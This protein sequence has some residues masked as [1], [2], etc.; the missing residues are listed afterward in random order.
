MS[1]KGIF[2]GWVVVVAGFLVL[3]AYSVQY[4]FGIFIEPISVEFSWS[5]MSLSGVYSLSYAVSIPFGLMWGKLVDKIGPRKVL[6][7]AG[8]LGG[9]GLLSAGLANSLLQ[10]YLAYGFLWGA[11]WSS[12]FRVS[13]AVIRRWFVRRAGLALGVAVCGISIGT[14]L[15]A[16]LTK[17]LITVVNW[18]AA[19][20]YVGVFVFIFVGLAALIIKGTPEEISMHPD[21]EVGLGITNQNELEGWEPRRAIGSLSFWATF[22]VML[23]LVF[24]LT[25]VTAHGVPYIT[26]KLT[27]VLNSK[28]EAGSLAAFAFGM[29]GLISTAGRLV[30]GILGDLLIRR[31]VQPAIS[32]KYMFS[33]SAIL[34]AIS[35]G[36][37]LYSNDLI[38]LTLWAIVFGV[39]YGFH[40]PLPGGIIGD[41]F[42]RK[43]IGLLFSIIGIAPGIGGI[44]GPMQA[45][46]IYDVTGSYEFSIYL[47]I[48]S[49]LLALFFT[50]LIKPSG[51]NVRD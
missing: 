38:G 45:G 46:Y 6:A 31:G 29:M 1:P 30:S 2:Y 4:M 44:I 5:R 33:T 10:L 28:E 43:N 8:F 27:T 12:F 7:F 32:R 18:R 50:F 17:F 13:N 15:L 51:D 41:L 19:F 48:F 47:A 11:G 22:F 26:Q 20:F 23:F 42:G 37:L 25:T 34:M 16:P 36:I 3:L 40:V 24:A 49:C 39:G 35:L 21:G 14:A 9:L